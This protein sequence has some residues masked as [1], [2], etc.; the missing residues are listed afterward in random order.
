VI[1]T[2]SIPVMHEQEF[3]SYKEQFNTQIK[4]YFMEYLSK[5]LQLDKGFLKKFYTIKCRGSV[6]EEEA[7]QRHNVIK[8]HTP[9]IKK[10]IGKQQDMFEDSRYHNLH[11]LVVHDGNTRAIKL[12][13]QLKDCILF[14]SGT[15][16]HVFIYG[17]ADTG[18][19]F[20]VRKLL[21][22]I[23][24]FLPNYRIKEISGSELKTHYAKSAKSGIINADWQHFHD[25][26][27]VYE[28]SQ[29]LI[30]SHIEDFTS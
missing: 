25:M 23:Q 9:D 2:L 8:D 3:K 1:L 16:K 7:K 5:V 30:I 10:M 13:N 12:L 14:N 20:M 21:E 4:D 15:T 28:N 11:D 19:T 24:T 18:K 22:K 26:K 6:D 29:L 27:E 17:D